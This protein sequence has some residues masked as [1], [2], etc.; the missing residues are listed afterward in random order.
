MRHAFDLAV[1]VGD[2]RPLG[3]DAKV[4][5]AAPVRLGRAAGLLGDDH[6]H[7]HDQPAAALLKVIDRMRARPLTTSRSSL[8]V[9]SLDRSLPIT[10]T[11]R[12]RRSGSR[13]IAPVVNRTR[14]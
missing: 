10:G 7:R 2:D 11:V 12:W 3:T 8:R 13:R 4:Y 1:M 14:P 6:L 5:A 9:F